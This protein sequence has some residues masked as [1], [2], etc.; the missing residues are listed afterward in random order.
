MIRSNQST[1]PLSEQL[2]QTHIDRRILPMFNDTRSRNISIEKKFYDIVQPVGQ[3]LLSKNKC[4][5]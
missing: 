1:A 3:N 2:K 5:G 4:L